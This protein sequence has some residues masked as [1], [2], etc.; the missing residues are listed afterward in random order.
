MGQYSR[1]S[2]H[3]ARRPWR[4]ARHAPQGQLAG[5]EL[6]ISH[7]NGYRRVLEAL[8]DASS[9]LRPVT[10]DDGSL[11]G[12]TGVEIVFPPYKYS[13][14]K[15]GNSF[16]A[17]AFKSLGDSGCLVTSDCGM[18]ININ[19]TGWDQRER[20]L[21]VGMLNVI[22]K[23]IIE[24]LGGR[25]LNGYCRQHSA[26]YRAPPTLQDYYSM[27]NGSHHSVC[28]VRANRLEMRFPAATTDIRKVRMLIDFA[29]YLEKFVKKAVATYPEYGLHT[30]VYTFVDVLPLRRHEVLQKFVEFLEAE[31]Q[32]PACKQLIKELTSDS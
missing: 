29:F 18:H 27:S 21:F 15:N 13:T 32:T 17:K 14:I 5:I 1:G 22:P 9:R 8:P 11:N 24:K 6:E 7:P 28:G 10:E 4:T 23:A 30:N 12:L 16:M 3:G 31:R 20:Y 26:E 2:Y 25:L 19:T